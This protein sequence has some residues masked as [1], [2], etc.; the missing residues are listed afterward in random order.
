MSF[1]LYAA[2]FAIV[3]AGLVYAAHLVHMPSHWILVGAVVMIGIGILSAVKA[4]RQKDAAS[5]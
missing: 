2:G 5:Q 1:G 4:T 3:I